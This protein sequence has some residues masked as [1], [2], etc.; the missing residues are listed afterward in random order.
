MNTREESGMVV[1]T[2]TERAYLVEILGWIVVLMD[3][4]MVISGIL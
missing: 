3:G 4:G 2:L 1:G